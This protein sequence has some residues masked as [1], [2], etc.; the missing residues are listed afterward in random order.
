MAASIAEWVAG[1]LLTVAAG[2]VKQTVVA[3]LVVYGQV[4]D[5]GS[6]HS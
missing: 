2:T 1:R 4:A 3:T 6:W 5:G